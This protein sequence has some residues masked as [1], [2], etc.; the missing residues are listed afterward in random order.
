MAKILQ[1]NN[2]NV[3][4]F[5]AP[6]LENTIKIKFN[7]EKTNSETNAKKNNSTF[8]LFNT[9]ELRQEAEKARTEAIES[10][11]A[12]I[13]QEKSEFEL[14]NPNINRNRSKRLKTK[15]AK[16]KKEFSFFNEENYFIENGLVEKPTSQSYQKSSYTPNYLF[17]L[18]PTGQR[19]L[20]KL[21][22]RKCI[23]CSSGKTKEGII[24]HRKPIE[25]ALQYAYLNFFPTNKKGERFIGIMI[26]DIDKFQGDYSIFDELIPHYIIRTDKKKRS[27]H[28]G[29]ILKYD[30]HTGTEKSYKK[31][32]SI[33]KKIATYL[34]A[35]P[36][37]TQ[38]NAKNPLSFAFDTILNDIP[39]YTLSELEQSINKIL[40][41]TDVNPDV[42][43][44]TVTSEWL[45]NSL[46]KGKNE[47]YQFDNNSRHCQYFE[48]IRF[49]AYEFAHDFYEAQDKK[50]FFDF[51]LN[52][53][54]L[55]YT[56]ELPPGIKYIIKD[57]IDFCFTKFVK[58]TEGKYGKINKKRKDDM[59]AAIDFIK[60]NY[61]LK[62]SLSQ[63][64][65]EQLLRRFEISERSLE[66]YISRARKEMRINSTDLGEKIYKLRKSDANVT[67]E[68]IARMF[69]RTI[70]SVK[71][72]E[73]R[74]KKRLL[75]E[76]SK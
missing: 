15:Q 8:E 6:T 69:E 57:V 12:K 20:D 19:I 37:F 4:S 48:Y 1:K 31:Y 60:K 40:N 11:I 55:G 32:T 21:G 9:K 13:G 3:K 18:H 41:I 65:K 29:Y 39:N 25:E 63:D 44:E 2:E 49:I 14:F 71:A 70:D 45:D 68:E 30:V 52:Q 58:N 7:V 22:R 73:K 53:S 16:K 24:F 23:K 67:W 47:N 43:S 74:Y 5:N 59:A 33:Y 17:H 34:N 35:D 26:F 64:E 62:K 42:V 66:T 75:E 28:V 27:I 50:A 61:D 72:L 76:S 36:C 46:T 54:K 51:L 10:E 56:G 38:T